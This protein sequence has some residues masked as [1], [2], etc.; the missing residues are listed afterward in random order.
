VPRATLA[1]LT[2]LAVAR[3][4]ALLLIAEGFAHLIA[5][6]AS[7]GAALA[8]A[9]LVVRALAGWGT[10]AVGRRAAAIAKRRDRAALVRGVVERDLDAGSVAVLASRGL[11]AV[12]SFYTAVVPTAIAAI[13]V[14]L[15]LLARV[16][17]A[18]PLSALILAVTLPLVPVFMILIGMHSRDRVERAQAALARLADHIAELARGLPV[19][20][21]L[22]RDREQAARLAALQRD[23]SERTRGVLRT[24]FLSALALELLATLS[25]AVVAVVLGIRLLGGDVGLF[26][27]LVVLLVAPECFAALRE[28]GA[29]HH[30]GDD[31]REVRDRVRRLLDAPSAPDPRRAAGAVRVSRLEVRYA[32]RRRPA[33]SGISLH[34]QPG[35]ILALTGASGAGKSS[36]LATLAGVLPSGTRTRGV[37]EV[38]AELAWVPQDPRCLAA[39]VRG[40]LARYAQGV[41]VDGVLDELGLSGLADLSPQLLSPGELRRV[42]VAR[43]LLRV[44]G[45]ARLLL[46]DEPTAHLDPASAAAVRA[47]ILRRTPHAAV[48]LV[49]HDPATLALA[50]RTVALDAHPVAVGAEQR[51]A[52]PEAPAPHRQAPIPV[53]GRRTALAAV[54]R[55]AGLLGVAAVLLGVAATGMGLALTAVSAWLIVR[56]AEQ[57]AVMYLL[58]AIV[59]VRF[60]GLGRAVARYVE[61][62][63]THRAAFRVVDDLRLRLWHGMSARGAASR[64]LREGGRAV[65]HLIGTAAEV[66]D[67]LPRTIP[68]LVVG[69]LTAVGVS[70]TVLLVAPGAAPLAA[71]GLVIALVAP[72]GLAV[73][74]GRRADVDRVTRSSLLLRGIAALGGASRDLR[75]NGVAAG[76]IADVDELSR[77]TARAEWRSGLVADAGVQLAPLL[78]GLSAVAAAALLAATGD[79]RATVAVVG[80][81]L[82]A[83]G[84]P[85]AAA[86]AGAHRVPA[87][88]A[89]LAPLAEVL[90]PTR[91]AERGT[92]PIEA[93][94]REVSFD[95]LTLGWPSGAPIATGVRARVRRGEVLFV[96]GPSGSGKT[97][98]LTTLLGDLPT[99]G[100]RLEVDGVALDAIDP[101]AWRA[102]VAWCPQEAH[103]FDSTLRGNLMIGRTRT[104]ALADDDLHDVLRRVGLT[105]LLEALDEGLDARVG[106]G[107][108]WL[109][110]GERQRLAVARTLLGDADVVLLDEPTAH[111]DAPTAAEVIA[112]LRRALAD[113]IVVL[114]SHRAA[115][116]GAQDVVLDLGGRPASAGDGCAGV[117]RREV[118]L[119]DEGDRRAVGDGDRT[120]REVL[121]R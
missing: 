14:P 25:V 60:F 84:E 48:V 68:P 42:A 108:R 87:L 116:R 109:S 73:L 72:A 101:A 107:G 98:L 64:D 119:V 20:V 29:A 33:V 85:L 19:L 59:G 53:G 78:A 63:V 62:L 66:R 69:V 11:D 45:G 106:P 102:R 47:A 55:P 88:L 32:G 105:P 82:L 112:D 16:L 15:G 38:P 35:E 12:D 18:D 2:V 65:D 58:V 23:S 90:A 89:A 30:A 114:V 74:V 97:T 8:G 37:V 4:G 95:D 22:G 57:P 27:A 7:V 79:P 113:R 110:G 80:L 50:D 86:V 111:L 115:D 17:L 117:Q 96:H 26:E 51:V 3:A 28:V 1:V 5:G 104:H 41:P 76:A 52:L 93:P 31:G 92:V 71:V 77:R 103:V 99:R 40:E 118:H 13:V 67:A 54:L 44:D 81:L 75:A 94:V 36:I 39:D 70:V 24:A 120:H 21:G 43:A 61:R 100:G 56:A 6:P 91:R 9:G 10:A 83:T 46:L 49:S 34:V 121:S